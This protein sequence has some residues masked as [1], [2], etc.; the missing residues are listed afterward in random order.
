MALPLPISSRQ[1]QTS[2]ETITIDQSAMAERHYTP[3]EIAKLWQVSVDLVRD[4][5]RKEPGVINL[6]AGRETARRTYATLRI[7]EYVLKRVY[8]RRQQG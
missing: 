3:Q 1:C 4:I 7:P 5:F 8:A 6:R 2:T